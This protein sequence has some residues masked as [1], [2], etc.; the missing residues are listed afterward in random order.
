MS[1]A[2]CSP[3]STPTRSLATPR[4]SK[5]ERVSRIASSRRTGFPR[6][7]I[8]RYAMARIS[9]RR[10]SSTSSQK[11][12]HGFMMRRVSKSPGAGD[13]LLMAVRAE[14]GN[15]RSYRVDSFF[16]ASPTQIG[17]SPGHPIELTPS[18]P[19]SILPTSRSTGI[20]TQRTS[21]RRRSRASSGGA[22]DVFRC[23]VCR[24]GFD[25]KSYDASLRPHKKL[26]RL[27]VLRLIRADKILGLAKRICRLRS[28]G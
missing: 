24:K 16:G 4:Y 5:A 7:S 14:D 18:G 10:F 22:I 21:T 23:P 17:F 3:A 28:V 27:S 20:V 1:S 13:V 11:S 19:Q 9:M 12:A 8:S 15:P 26:G 6:T 25:R 2:G